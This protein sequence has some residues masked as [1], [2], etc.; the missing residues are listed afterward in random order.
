MKAEGCEGWTPRIPE[1]SIIIIIMFARGIL[2]VL[3]CQ[4]YALRHVLRISHL[5]VIHEKSMKKELRMLGV[6]AVKQ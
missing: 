2:L 3:W 6:Y 5:A 1:F 4:I